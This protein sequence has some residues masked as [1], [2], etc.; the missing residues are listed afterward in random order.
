MEFVMNN[1]MNN[2]EAPSSSDFMKMILDH[3]NHK[4]WTGTPDYFW[5]EDMRDSQLISE[6][7]A[8]Y[9]WGRH[10]LSRIIIN[11][12]AFNRLAV[13]LAQIVWETRFRSYV[14]THFTL[15]IKRT[16]RVSALANQRIVYLL[17]LSR[18]A[19]N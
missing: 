2:K 19:I 6:E 8:I 17:V 3:S 13:A 1:C 15:L 14:A 10:H 7:S 9:R 16:P 4:G 18:F 5:V 12:T 11:P